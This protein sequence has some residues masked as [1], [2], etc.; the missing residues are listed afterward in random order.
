LNPPLYHIS[1]PTHIMLK[2]VLLSL[3]TLAAGDESAYQQDELVVQHPVVHVGLGDFFDKEEVLN[4][5]NNFF[6][7]E[8]A[9]HT[10]F[11]KL[12]AWKGDLIQPIALFGLGLFALFTVFRILIS[13][14]GGVVNLKTDLFTGF[15]EAVGNIHKNFKE[16]LWRRKRR[17]VEEMTDRVVK[18]LH[19]YDM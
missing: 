8:N 15:T 17:D 12:M 2:I 19:K 7:L 3:L 14:M 13:V 16:S 10:T 9:G 5:I 1:S 11:G 6:S 18:A 4:S